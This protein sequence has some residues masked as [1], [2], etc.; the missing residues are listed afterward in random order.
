MHHGQ[1]YSSPSS[2]IRATISIILQLLIR[3]SLANHRPSFCFDYHLQSQ[4]ARKKIHWPLPAHL[5]GHAHT[6]PSLCGHPRLL[7]IACSSGFLCVIA[8]L[9]LRTRLWLAFTRKPKS[10]RL[11]PSSLT[12]AH[13]AEPQANA[14]RPPHLPLL[15]S[16]VSKAWTAQPSTSALP[17]VILSFFPLTQRNTMLVTR[18]HSTC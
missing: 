11:D 17:A 16:Q 1:L 12:C 4:Q 18:R 10:R 14:S 8:A 7:S 5:Y 13:C 15:W 9:H 3:T 2:C 6:S